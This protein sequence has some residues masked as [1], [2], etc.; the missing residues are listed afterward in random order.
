MQSTQDEPGVGSVVLVDLD[1]T[2]LPDRSAAWAAVEATLHA[3]GVPRPSET[4]QSAS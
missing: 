4:V 1:D 3:V 2:L